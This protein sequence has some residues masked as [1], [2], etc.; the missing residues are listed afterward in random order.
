LAK[1]VADVIVDSLIASGVRRIYGVSGDS[2]NGITDKR[3]DFR[4]GSVIGG[5]PAT[6][7]LVKQ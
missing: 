2:L 5:R 7:H 4:L 3:C 1:R 6:T